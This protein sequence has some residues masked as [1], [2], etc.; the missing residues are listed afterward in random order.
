L[1]INCAPRLE[2][3]TPM[4]NAIVPLKAFFESETSVRPQAERPDGL[5]RLGP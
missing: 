1:S 5:R 2:I 4:R 3:W